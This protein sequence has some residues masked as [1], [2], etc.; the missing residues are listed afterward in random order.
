M[1]AGL[2]WVVAALALSAIGLWGA[3]AGAQDLS[4]WNRNKGDCEFVLKAPERYPLPSVNECVQLWEQYRDVSGLS[5]DE[6]ALYGRGPSW[7]FVQGVNADQKAL[8]RGS[9]NRMNIIEAYCF[10]GDRWDIACGKAG[11][12]RDSFVELK[13]LPKVTPKDVGKGARGKASKLNSE[14]LR[15]YKKRAYPAAIAK[16][17]QAL[18]IDPFYV[19]AKFNLACNQSLVGDKQGALQTLLELQSWD[20][21]EAQAAFQNARK[22]KDFEPL[23]NDRQF[24]QLLGLI[25]LQILNGAQEPGL[26]H[27]GRIHKD[28]SKRNYVVHSYGYDRHIRKRPLI[29]YREGYEQ[30]A[31]LAKEIVSNLRTA[32]K[33]INWDSPYDVIVVW[34]D[35]EVA[36]RTG[37][38][39][40]IVQGTGVKRDPN[41]PL[42]KILEAKD[43]LQGQ[44]EQIQDAAQ[45]P[46]LPGAP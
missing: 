23:Y 40:P 39:G 11:G 7:L 16:F 44:S 45:P 26:F 20:S 31:Q 41:D 25:R 13:P 37:T 19:K 38:G 24:R 36:Q 22:D 8:A 9:L 1:T 43:K 12:G 28:F 21:G 29:Y 35:P 32:V 14:G 46:P 42:G 18:K 15:A 33:K 5:P 2:R 10:D 17:E 27:V 3:T 34:G 4:Q 6:R 30:Q